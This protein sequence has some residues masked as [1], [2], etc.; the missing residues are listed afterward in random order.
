MIP[1]AVAR[2]LVATGLQA[3]INRD[4]AFSVMA[5]WAQL[6]NFASDARTAFI[7]EVMAGPVPRAKVKH[8]RWFRRHDRRALP[9]DQ[10]HF[11]ALWIVK[12][13]PVTFAGAASEIVEVSITERLDAAKPEVLR[14]GRRLASVQF[15]IFDRD[16]FYIFGHDFS[17]RSLAVWPHSSQ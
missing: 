11:A 14:S 9:D 7:V 2:V 16:Q 13:L 17:L 15:F 6:F 4:R 1:T 12:Y 3:T 5:P 10:F 8:A